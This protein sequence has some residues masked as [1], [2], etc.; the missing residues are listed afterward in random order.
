MLHFLR[1]LLVIAVVWLLVLAWTTSIQGSTPSPIA[2]A[3]V[4]PTSQPTPRPP[5]PSVSTPYVPVLPWSIHTYP[6]LEAFIAEAQTNVN[7]YWLHQPFPANRPYAPPRVELMQPGQSVPCAARLTQWTSFYCPT[8]RTIYLYQPGLQIGNSWAGYAAMYATLAHE[9]THQVQFILG[10]PQ[11]EP[12]LELQADCGSGMFLAA[13]WPDMAQSDLEP[14]RRLL[15]TTP[16]DAAHGTPTQR[17]AAFDNG[18]Q[19]GAADHCGLP[20]AG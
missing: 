1:L 5:T 11:V 7:D 20:I 2:P 12:Q 18:Y 16:S 6:S 9:F 15:A 13:A 8:E 4:V 14:L 10:V 19:R 17:L 3:A